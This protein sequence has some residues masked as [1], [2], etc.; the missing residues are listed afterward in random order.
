MQRREPDSTSASGR[1]KAARTFGLDAL[2]LCGMKGT[3]LRHFGT[4]IVWGLFQIFMILTATLG[5]VFSGEREIPRIW[6]ELSL[7]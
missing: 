5:G 1:Y 3:Y 4:S 7:S 6:L 2:S